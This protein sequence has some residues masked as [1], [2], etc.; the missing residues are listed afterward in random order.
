MTYFLIKQVIRLINH[1]LLPPPDL[2][3]PPEL[4][5]PPP[6]L[7]EPPPELLI[8]EDP[9]E[10]L[11]ERMP[12]DLVLV[13]REFIERVFVALLFVLRT[14]LLLEK[15]EFL[16]V[17][18][19]F[20]LLGFLT[21]LTFPRVADVFLALRTPVA[22]VDRTLR[23]VPLTLALDRVLVPRAFRAVVLDLLVPPLT[24]E[25]VPLAF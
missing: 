14:P 17:A 3:P 16:E 22:L 12:L 24:S 2:P 10:E 9:L 4:L 21:L 25:R 11:P 7:L 19:A 6:E 23:L 20:T 5:P 15:P 13:E 1:Y 18:L 8:V